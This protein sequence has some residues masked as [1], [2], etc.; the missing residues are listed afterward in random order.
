MYINNK[1]YNNFRNKVIK[2]QLFLKHKFKLNK[3]VLEHSVSLIQNFFRKF[4]MNKKNI[5]K[6][7]QIK[8]QIKE[9]IPTVK[10]IDDLN[11]EVEKSEM[12]VR[13][14]KMEQNFNVLLEKITN[15]INNE[16]IKKKDE[17][18][19]TLNEKVKEQEKIIEEDNKVKME[20]GE[21]LQ[22]LLITLNNYRE[23]NLRLRQVNNKKIG[24]LFSW[25]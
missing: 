9:E 23:E 25:W 24:G 1:K 22:K 8:K 2:L 15:G 3:M 12:E 21:R 4:S 11:N 14:E 10:I 13:M 20:M 17:K 19:E 5:E 16:E 18:I 7:K 6:S